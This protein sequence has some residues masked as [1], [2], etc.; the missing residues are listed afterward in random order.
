MIDLNDI[1]C[2]LKG[3]DAIDNIVNIF[4]YHIL[5]GIPEDT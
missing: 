1:R 4:F 3:S 5:K 2:M